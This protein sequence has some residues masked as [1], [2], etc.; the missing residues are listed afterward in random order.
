LFCAHLARQGRIRRFG[1]RDV[2]A[3]VSMHVVFNNNYEDQGQ[4]NARVLSC[5]VCR[6]RKGR[7]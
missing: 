7:G 6:K 3:A 1:K 4:R 2:I 5:V